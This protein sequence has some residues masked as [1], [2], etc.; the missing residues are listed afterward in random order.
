MALMQGKVVDLTA[1]LAL[2]AARL[3]LSIHLPLADS[4][5]LAT[6][7]ALD[8]TVWTQDAHFQGLDKVVFRPKPKGAG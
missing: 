7:R 6:A 1:N 8:A 4:V 3:S 2:E 5:I